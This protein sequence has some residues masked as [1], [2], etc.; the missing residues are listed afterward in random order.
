MSRV[1]IGGAGGRRDVRLC[2]MHCSSEQFSFQMCLESGDGNR[3]FRNRGQHQ[4]SIIN[5]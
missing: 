4:S 3:T 2:G 5:P 1:R